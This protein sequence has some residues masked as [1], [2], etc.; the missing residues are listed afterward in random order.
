MALK[1]LLAW[2]GVSLWLALAGSAANAASCLDQIKSTGVLKV[3]IGL[4]GLKPYVWQEADGSYTGF[5]KEML[6]YVA[7]KLGVRYEYVVTEWQTLIPGLKSERWDIIWSGMAK[8]QER[9]QGGGIDYTE[10]YL[11]IFDRIIVLKDSGI[12]GLEDLKG[13]TLASTL[14]TMD[15]LVGHSL[16][17]AGHAEKII[18]FNTFGEPFLALRNGDADAVI[19]D[20][21]TYLA[22]REEMPDLAA[23]GEPLF[24][25]P[26]PEWKE[27]EEQADYRLGALAVGVRRECT[28]LKDAISATIAEMDKDGTREKILRAYSI[29]SDD[30]KKL[31]KD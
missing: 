6:D 24:Y 22:Q 12:K 5:E 14:G 10:P 13:K 7:D 26:K 18:D 25:I 9:I 15:S 28:D 30:Q 11:L 8:T 21:T 23:V 31:K 2:A 17:D 19:M 20:E 4:M 27:A 3:G 1:K 16:V 29:W